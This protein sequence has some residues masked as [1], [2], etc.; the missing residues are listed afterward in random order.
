M[1]QVVQKFRCR[2]RWDRGLWRN[3]Y[4]FSTEA[5]ESQRGLQQ[6]R[7]S[8]I[9]A[10]GLAGTKGEHLPRSLDFWI[11]RTLQPRAPES[12]LLPTKLVPSMRLDIAAA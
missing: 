9:A 10:S 3:P 12:G 8:R 1:G 4:F 7:F 2:R 11:Y 5:L 6:Q